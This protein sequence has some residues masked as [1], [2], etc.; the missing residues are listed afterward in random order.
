[1]HEQV[2]AEGERVDVDMQVVSQSSVE[3]TSTTTQPSTDRG[4]VI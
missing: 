3:P 2:A 4:A 1:M